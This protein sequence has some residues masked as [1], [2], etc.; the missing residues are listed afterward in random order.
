MEEKTTNKNKNTQKATSLNPEKKIKTTDN[1]YEKKETSKKVSVKKGKN[2]STVET[3]KSNTLDSSN[4]ITN[5]I[6]IILIVT[7]VF[8]IFYGI[9]VLVT[10]NKRPEKAPQEEPI[11][12]YDEILLGNLLQQP[13]KEYYV[14]VTLEDDQYASAYTTYLSTYASKKGHLRAYKANLDSGFN[15]TYKAEQSH[16][17]ITNIKDLKLKGS[18]LLKIRSKKIVAAYEGNAKIIE[19]LKT[20]IK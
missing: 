5:L 3:T 20:L 2:K 13:N 19:H 12:Q 17:N 14:L 8:L 10:K 4:E 9:T 7:A 15:K 1:N 11:I 16:T 18:T 6:K